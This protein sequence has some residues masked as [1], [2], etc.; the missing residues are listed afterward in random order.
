MNKMSWTWSEMQEIAQDRKARGE[1][2][3]R[4]VEEDLF[5]TYGRGNSPFVQMI[6]Y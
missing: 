5:V 6:L 3:R 2:S 4:N 1:N